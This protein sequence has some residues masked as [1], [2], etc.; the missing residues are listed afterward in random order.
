MAFGDPVQ[1]CVYAAW[2]ATWPSAEDFQLSMPILWPRYVRSRVMSSTS[3]NPVPSTGL[4]PLPPAI[5]GQWARQ[6]PS[7]TSHGAANLLHKQEMRLEKD[8][9]VVSRVL[10]DAE[11]DKYVYNWLI[12]NT[13]SFYYELSCVKRTR[14]RSDCMVLCPFVD[15]FNHAD[16]GVSYTLCS[17]RLQD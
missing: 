4:F 8:W 7:Y 1:T 10:P 15:C 13:R 14:S 2:R 11:Y 17:R 3:T 9:A 12:V 5:G 6:N 16:R